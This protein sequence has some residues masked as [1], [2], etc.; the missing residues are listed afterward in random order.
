MSF[1][2][3]VLQSSAS[4]ALYSSLACCTA[5]LEFKAA[6]VSCRP[7]PP[8]CLVPLGL[9]S[10]PF[11]GN[12]DNDCDRLN[13]VQ[14][15]RCFWSAAHL[16][17]VSRIQPTSLSN[18]S[19]SFS[20]LA[21][22]H[23]TRQCSECQ[24]W[25]GTCVLTLMGGDSRPSSFCDSQGTEL[26]HWTTCFTVKHLILATLFLIDFATNYT[27]SHLISLGYCMSVHPSLSSPQCLPRRIC[28]H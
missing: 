1:F 15:A 28:C 20:L 11:S 5:F 10:A 27:R 2:L 14:I 17:V 12:A 26:V 21:A 16:V 19:Y 18:W 4:S 3:T 13:D 23:L 7:S 9:W 22:A 8:V 24:A 6:A 25:D